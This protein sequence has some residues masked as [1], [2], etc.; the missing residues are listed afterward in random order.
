MTHIS[1]T[2]T[3]RFRQ[4]VSRSIPRLC[5]VV[6]GFQIRVCPGRCVVADARHPVSRHRAFAA[7]SDF[8][9]DYTH[10]VDQS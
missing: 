8:V 10:A 7:I 1:H 6:P 2:L 4:D 9:Q 3:L 5:L